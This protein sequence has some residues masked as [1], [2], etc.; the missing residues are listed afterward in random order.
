MHETE[1]GRKFEY[2]SA[3]SKQ[4]SK[5]AVAPQNKEGEHSMP[6]PARAGDDS[7]DD[8]LDLAASGGDKAA[9]MRNA[10]V[11]YKGKEGDV[12]LYE[13]RFFWFTPSELNSAIH[14]TYEGV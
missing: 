13:S 5:D 2:S 8:E 14:L 12:P 1:D 6:M 9:A 11:A 3:D 4:N 10:D 7:D